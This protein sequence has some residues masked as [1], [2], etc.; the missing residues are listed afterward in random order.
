MANRFVTESLHADSPDN[1]QSVSISESL[2]RSPSRNNLTIVMEKD[3]M[4]ENL[5]LELAETQRKLEQMRKLE[6]GQLENLQRQLEEVRQVNAR[7]S[8]EHE[9]YQVLLSER[10]LTGNFSTDL[11]YSGSTGEEKNQNS[12]IRRDSTSLADELNSADNENMNT[13]ASN[14]GTAP[15]T[16]TP[17]RDGSEKDNV[18]DYQQQL[19]HEISSLK[20]QN[21]AL[22]L[23]IEK[24]IS[25][26]LQHDGFE[27][28]LDRPDRSSVPDSAQQNGPAQAPPSKPRTSVSALFSRMNKP[29]PLS[30]VTSSSGTSFPDSL[31]SGPSISA[32]SPTTSLQGTSST[33]ENPQTAPSI[34]FQTNRARMHRRVRSDQVGAGTNQTG[35]IAG[36]VLNRPGNSP[37]A[38]ANPEVSSMSGA[39]PV[40]L[41]PGPDKSPVNAGPDAEPASATRP[42]SIRSSIASVNPSVAPKV[43]TL[44]EREEEEKEEGGASAVTSTASIKRMSSPSAR[45]ERTGEVTSAAGGPSPPRSLRSNVTT[46]SNIGAV[47]AGVT[48]QNRL[49]PLTLVNGGEIGKGADAAAAQKKANRTSWMSWFQKKDD[50]NNGQDT[51]SEIKEHE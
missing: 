20:E 33:L 18:E 11:S 37:G 10:T 32:S 26:L 25:R 47:T 4:I 13:S 43:V 31:A 44:N 22:T 45:S 24:I 41:F 5:R 28:I 50:G 9:T 8:E 7:L 6:G 3:R 1:G 48:T 21:K 36:Q 38:S 14:T 35:S 16:D 46:R 40:S 42:G 19:E 23:Y 15:S 51:V 34:P 39:M 49:R 12:Q 29:R 2:K 17:A 30:Q 27:S